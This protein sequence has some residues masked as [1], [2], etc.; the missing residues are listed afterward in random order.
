MSRP[1]N[2]NSSWE[3]PTEYLA[4]NRTEAEWVA[5]RDAL[6]VERI[7]AN[8]GEPFPSSVQSYLSTIRAGSKVSTAKVNLD[9]YLASV[10]TAWNAAVTN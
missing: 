1:F 6:A 4:E 10:Q 5:L 8:H 3:L 7:N 9:T 2:A